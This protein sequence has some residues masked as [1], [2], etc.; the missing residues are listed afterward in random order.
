[1]NSERRRFAL[2][3]LPPLYGIACLGGILANQF[4]IVAVVG[5]LTLAVLYTGLIRAGRQGTGRNRNRN[6]NRT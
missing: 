3:V 4:V 2:Y 1:M 6:R 5:A